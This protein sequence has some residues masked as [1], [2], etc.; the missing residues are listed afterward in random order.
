[1]SAVEIGQMIAAEIQEAYA[2]GLADGYTN[3]LSQIN[4]LR[5][6]RDEC[7][8]QYQAKTT[9]VLV[10]MDRVDALTAENAALRRRVAAL[11]AVPLG[12]DA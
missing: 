1:M 10:E 3:G 9:A 12:G 2:K 7:E 5:A 11:A 4:E 8:R 6:A